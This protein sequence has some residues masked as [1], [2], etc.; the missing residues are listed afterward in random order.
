M[1]A[2]A[3][4]EAMNDLAADVH[5]MALAKGW[6]EQ[7]VAFPEKVALIHTELSEALEQ[8][9]AGY[10]LDE[11]YYA[12]DSCGT[13]KPEGVPI[14]LADTVLRILDL[15][16]WAG[17]DIGS[18]IARKMEYNETRQYRHGGKLC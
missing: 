4:L 8:F 15:C 11:M 16:S 14:E 12:V 17:I 3:A 9:R 6:Y 7:P 13:P 2:A 10:A 18:A 1:S 5:F